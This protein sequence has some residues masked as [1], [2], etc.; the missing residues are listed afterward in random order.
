PL[1]C[2]RIVSCAGRD[3]PVLGNGHFT[4]HRR[5]RG[6][7]NRQVRPG[8]DDRLPAWRPA[9]STAMRRG[10]G[11]ARR[12]VCHRRGA[13]FHCAEFRSMPATATRP[14]A[15]PD[16]PAL[17]TSRSRVPPLL[18]VWVP[19]ISAAIISGAVLAW[20]FPPGAAEG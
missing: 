18:P 4:L 7:V 5:D 20:M 11:A 3:L 16:Q 9:P 12:Q 10:R 14:T 2:R 13:R 15:A 17:G 6:A 19:L 8:G 1:P